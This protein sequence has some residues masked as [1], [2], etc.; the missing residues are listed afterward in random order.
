[1]LKHNPYLFVYGSLRQGFNHPAYTYITQF[2]T[3]IGTAKV[4]GIMYDLG[5]YPAVVPTLSENYIVGE[6]YEIKNE[7]ELDWAMAQLDDYEGVVMEAGETPEYVRGLT[8]VYMHN[9]TVIANIYWRNG[10]VA[11]YP[12]VASGDIFEYIKQKQK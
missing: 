8:T 10:D 5:D 2:F 12:V 3:L 6:L 4:K 11:N 1:M 9:D 7:N